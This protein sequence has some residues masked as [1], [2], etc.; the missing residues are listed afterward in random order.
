MQTS[1]KGLEFIQDVEGCKLFAYLDTGGV[2][3][4]GVG[5]TGPE[6]VKGLSCTME[7]AMKW[8]AED[9]TEAQEAVNKLVKVPL[10]QNQFDALVSFVFNVGVNAFAKSTM[11]RKLNLGDYAGASKEF[12]RWNKDNGKE[13]L[14]LTKRRLLEQGV[15]NAI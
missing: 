13:I 6:V 5:H 7:Q 10:T 4:I 3:T 12:P 11:L 14:G 9:S 1:K 2:W 15:F 8:L